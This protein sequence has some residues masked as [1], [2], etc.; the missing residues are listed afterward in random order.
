[1]HF[2]I[3]LLRLRQIWASD[4]ETSERLDSAGEIPESSAGVLDDP[5]KA[6]VEAETRGKFPRSR[7]IFN[8]DD[9]GNFDDHLNLPENS[10]EDFT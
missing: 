10:F 3:E 2:H 8:F 6:L 9:L 7:T 4:P 5:S 1:M